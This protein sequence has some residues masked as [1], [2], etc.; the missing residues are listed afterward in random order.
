[1]SNFGALWDVAK[2]VFPATGNPQGVL[3]LPVGTVA[4]SPCGNLYIK[5]GG[6]STAFGW[7]LF[8]SDQFMQWQPRLV[9]GAGQMLGIAAQT[10]AVGPSTLISQLPSK[11]TVAGEFD[12]KRQYVGGYTS[13]VIGNSFL[14]TL[15]NNIDMNP[16]QRTDTSVA[17]DFCE[18][19]CWWDLVTTPRASS[20]TAS[21]DLTTN[22]MRIWAG[23]AWGAAVRQQVGGTVSSDTL[24]TEWPTALAVAN[25]LFGWAFRW[26]SAVDGANWRLV[27]TNCVGG[28]YGQTVTDMLVPIAA[29]TAYRLRVR[30]VLVSGVLTCL[31]SINDG[32]EIA[33]T[34][35]VGP[36]VSIPNQ[37]QPFQPLCSVRQ[38]NATVKSLA[39]AQ[40]AM[41]YG[42][43]VGLSGC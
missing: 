42:L 14:Y 38:I 31:A 10:L 15:L 7:Y 4:V 8:G 36:V 25:N 12:P 24:A 9:V 2:P 26:S 33:V 18:F 3:A 23:G 5:R 34:A 22:A 11:S 29:N 39:V 16:S 28:A 37:T 41:N 35:N 32:A 6:G 1:M 20:L 30:F 43:G 40:C 17:A 21:T 13:G 27:T 19:D